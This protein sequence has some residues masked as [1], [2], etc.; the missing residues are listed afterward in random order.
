MTRLV[1]SWYCLM[2]HLPQASGMRVQCD[3]G[4]EG[5]GDEVDKAAA[6]H[7]DV[8]GHSTRAG[9]EAQR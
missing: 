8:T 5:T 6:E 4:G 3:A 1:C 2:P 7:T 9:C